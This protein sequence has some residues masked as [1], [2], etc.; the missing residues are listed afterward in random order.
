M[1][2][3]ERT[4]W[5]KMLDWELNAIRGEKVEEREELD[6]P[7]CGKQVERFRIDGVDKIFIAGMPN[8]DP[9]PNGNK[10]VFMPSEI[11]LHKCPR[12]RNWLLYWWPF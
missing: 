8:P 1:K 12:R 6:C 9:L 10:V 7:K 2:P 3:D 11:H 5:E 4:T